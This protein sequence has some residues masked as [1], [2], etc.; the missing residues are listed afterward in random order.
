M[1]TFIL[2]LFLIA[3]G[4]AGYFTIQ[5]FF[6]KSAPIRNEQLQREA[7][8]G[9]QCYYNGKIY[10]RGEKFPSFD[11]CNTCECKNDPGN[12]TKPLITCSKKVCEEKG[13]FDF[14]KK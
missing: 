12:A 6:I 14:L 2:L 8:A 13:F 9:N 7:E 11:G 10:G 1:R 3:L 4:A 5:K